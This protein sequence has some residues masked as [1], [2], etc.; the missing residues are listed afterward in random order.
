MHHQLSGACLLVQGPKFRLFEGVVS[1]IRLPVVF[2]PTSRCVNIRN[3][4]LDDQGIPIFL[5]PFPVYIPPLFLL[6][7][8]AIITVSEASAHYGV[9]MARLI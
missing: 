3:G 1:D 2:L 8:S 7:V 4:S 5:Q 6:L 9:S